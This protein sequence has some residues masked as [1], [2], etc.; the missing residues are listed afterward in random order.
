MRLTTVSLCALGGIFPLF[1]LPTLPGSLV[2]SVLFTLA[3]LLGLFRWKVAQCTG[4][5][6]LFFLW[7]VMGGEAVAVGGKYIARHHAEGG[8]RDY[9][10]G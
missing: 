9:C 8:R 2:V 4:L 3:C 7:G 1:L 5:F 6:L 10:H